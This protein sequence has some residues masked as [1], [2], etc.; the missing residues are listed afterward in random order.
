VDLFGPLFHESLGGKKYC[1]VILLMAIQDM[2]GFIS[3]ERRV[4][5]NKP[6]STLQKNLYVN[7]STL[8]SNKK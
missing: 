7:V 8:Y 1:L 5:P 2:H 3:F 4:I 6:S